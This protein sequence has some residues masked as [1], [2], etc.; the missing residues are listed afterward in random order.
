MS[1]HFLLLLVQDLM[2][3]V[4]VLG[5]DL[6]VALELGVGG[7][8]VLV[9]CAVERRS[10]DRFGLHVGTFLGALG[11][12]C[13]GVLGLVGTATLVG[14]GRCGFN[15]FIGAIIARFDLEGS[16]GFAASF[17]LW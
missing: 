5:F 14:W 6:D 2:L 13:V 17:F 10:S 9:F 15:V 7:A 11:R 8:V 1:D 3:T 12:W 4:L 16:F